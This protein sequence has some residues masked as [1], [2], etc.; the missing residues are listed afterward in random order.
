MVPAFKMRGLVTFLLHI[1]AKSLFSDKARNGE[2]TWSLQDE[3]LPD[4]TKP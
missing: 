4:K 1:V 2:I 3:A